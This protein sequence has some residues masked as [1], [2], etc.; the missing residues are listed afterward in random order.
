[1]SACQICNTTVLFGGKRAAGLR[2]CSQRCL[3]AGEAFV[4]AEELPQDVVI[5]P[6]QELF[7]GTCPRCNGD[8]PIDVY[9]SWWIH[10]FAIYSSWETRQHVSCRPCGRKSQ[11]G[12]L[13][14]SLIA[15]WW[16]IPFGLLMTPVQIVR[17]L[18]GMLR[19]AP[20]SPSL[21]LEKQVRLLLAR[22]LL[23]RK[24]ETT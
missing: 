11:L 1:M 5:E 10:S 16:G 21:L 3:D 13:L 12:G 14:Y 20:T 18:I 7:S 15:G 6:L 23:Q 8:G 22:D 24:V 19:S 17:N 2:F 9:Q 4:I